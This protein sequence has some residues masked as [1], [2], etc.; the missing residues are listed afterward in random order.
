MSW[1]A[2]GALQRRVALAVI[3]VL[4][5]NPSVTMAGGGPPEAAPRPSPVARM[6]SLAVE[7]EPA[8]AAVYVDGQLTGQTPLQ[9]AGLTAGDHRV[10]LVKGGYLENARVV[11]VGATPSAVRVRLTR[12]AGSRPELA[13]QLGGGGGGGGEG[14]GRS[15]L[16]LIAALAGGGAVAAILI[17]KKGSDSTPTNQPPTA[18]SFTVSPT[19]AILNTNTTFTAVGASDPEGD[20]LSYSWN[21]GDGTPAGTGATATHVYTTAT[22]FP[23]TLTV[24]ATGGSASTTPT[25]LVVKSLAATWTGGPNFGNGCWCP[26]PVTVTLTQSGTT[27]GGG[28][29]DTT[30]I[31][32]ISGSVNVTTRV[33][34]F[35]VTFT[36]PPGPSMNFTAG[37]LNATATT[38]TGTCNDISG[39][40][41]SATPWTMTRP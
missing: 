5:V 1:N 32:T 19:T 16:P 4:A 17:A 25:N 39:T 31:G 30:D 9:V 7:S 21:F 38:L 20:A 22:T 24:T 10:R 3:A 23:V 8:G 13:A 40:S 26:N 12:D 14:G 28:F 6:G 36:T 2:G 41:C 37:S 11:S 18:G 34:T 29:N 33:V 15:K 35:T 27:I